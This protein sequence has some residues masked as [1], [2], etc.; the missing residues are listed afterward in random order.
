MRYSPIPAHIA[1]ESRS[2]HLTR[3]IT[4]TLTVV[5][6]QTASKTVRR[7]RKQKTH[8]RVSIKTGAESSQNKPRAG[9]RILAL[10]EAIRFG[11][12]D[13]FDA[14]VSPLS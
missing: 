10:L 1:T 11:T 5:P 4:K 13:S 6:K 12:L 3:N 8:F 9:G 14:N 2:H 7:F